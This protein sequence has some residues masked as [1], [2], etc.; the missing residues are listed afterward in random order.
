MVWGGAWLCTFVFGILIEAQLVCLPSTT[1]W[2][3]GSPMEKKKAEKQKGT[4]NRKKKK[5]KRKVKDREKIYEKKKVSEREWKTSVRKIKI[6]N[7]I[8]FSFLFSHSIHIN[9]SK[10]KKDDSIREKESLYYS[11]NKY[12]YSF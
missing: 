11:K 8:R 6:N 12:I 9:K 7:I 5:R 4:S 3:G 1:K 10:K 2:E